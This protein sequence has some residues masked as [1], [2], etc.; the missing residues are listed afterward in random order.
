M[1]RILLSFGMLL[2]AFQVFQ[3]ANS[4][5]LTFLFRNGQ[6][7]AGPKFQFEIWIKSSDGTSRMGS[8]L[9]YNNY[10]TGAFG[11][12]VVAGGNVTVTKNATAFGASYAVNASNDNTT[13]RFAYSWFY[14]G[15]TGNGVVIPSTG[16]GVLAYTIQ[17]NIQNLSQ[18]AGLSFEQTLMDGEQYL[19]D[20][21]NP[22][23]VIDATNVLDP[24][25]PITLSS[26]AA[27]IVNQ[28]QVRL[29]WT[30]LTETNNYGFEVQKSQGNQ[31]N[32]ETIPNSF[33]P[34]HGTTIEPHS[35]SYADNLASVGSW[36]YRLKQIDLDATV[37]FT[38]GIQVDVLTGVNEK[39]LPKEFALDQ[40]Y[41][42]PFNP[43][44]NIEY[45]VPRES[46]VQLVVYNVLGQQ[47]A[48]LVDEVKS[49]G[50][51]TASFNAISFSSGLYFYRMNAGEVSILKK[52]MLVK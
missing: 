21:T 14:T 46:R 22:W 45:A 20:E 23:P 9:V 24:P 18:N 5:T 29:D 2:A 12:N 42:N 4:Q 32:Y 1:K 37:H 52:M 17:I 33:I 28:N 43:S 34:G 16:D 44:T 8:I 35:Y 49:A 38:E 6:I 27:T 7:V 3:E 31:N 25:L 47:V 41:P 13:S 50:Y 48:T 15:G 26:F 10:N 36:Y 30:T 40:N 39:P 19:D 11:T 51:H